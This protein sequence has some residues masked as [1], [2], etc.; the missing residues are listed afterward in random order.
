MSLMLLSLLL[1]LRPSISHCSS[2]RFCMLVLL[3]LLL[4]LLQPSFLQATG[5]SGGCI[6]HLAGVHADATRRVSGVCLQ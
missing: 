4:L 1:L 3:S 6:F 5:S 2:N